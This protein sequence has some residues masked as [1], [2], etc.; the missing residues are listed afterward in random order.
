MLIVRSWSA[1]WSGQD[2]PKGPTSVPVRPV[3]DEKVPTG[4]PLIHSLI[5]P[6][7]DDGAASS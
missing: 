3:L 7:M 1:P 5:E 2:G 6:E 4:A